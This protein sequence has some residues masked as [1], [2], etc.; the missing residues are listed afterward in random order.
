[1][2]SSS[3]ISSRP[4]KVRRNGTVA[5]PTPT[6]PI[7]SDS[8]SVTDTPACSSIR[9]RAAAAIQPEVPPPTITTFRIGPQRGD[10]V[11]GT[12]IS[13]SQRRSFHSRATVSD[14]LSEWLRACELNQLTIAWK[15]TAGEVRLAPDLRK[16]RACFIVI[17]ERTGARTQICLVPHAEEHVLF[18]CFR[19]FFVVLIDIFVFGW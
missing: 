3:S 5:S 19:V 14:R 17:P 6:V 4:L 9:A 8:T 13:D 10:L 2:K 12:L 1:M 11:S 7:S 15:R 18:F 16:G